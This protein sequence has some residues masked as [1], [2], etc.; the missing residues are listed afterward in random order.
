MKRLDV[1][2]DGI[3]RN[4]IRRITGVSMRTK[5]LGM[6]AGVVLLLG[7]AVTLQVR[8]RLEADLGASLEER[9]IAIA[10][11]LA[12]RSADLILTE[13]TFALHQLLRDTIENN[14][15]VRYVFMLDTNGN[16]L[17]QSFGQSVPR[18]LLSLNPV[19]SQSAYRVQVLDSE[20]G[21][22]D[23]VAMP[24]LSGRVGV[25]RVGLSQRRLADSV[26]AATWGLIGVTVIALVLGLAVA[27]L[28]THILT[29]PVTE[30][31]N[32]ARS[33][34]QGD[35]SVKARRHTDDEIGELASAFNTMTG[36]LVRSRAELLRRMSELGAL[37]TTAVAISGG[38]SLNHTLQAALDKVLEVMSLRAGWI[39]LVADD[40][41]PA[42][43]LAVQSGL[44]R[45]FASE[46]SERELG[47][48]VCARVLRNGQPLMVNDI[49]RE[50]PRLSADVI[51]AEGLICHA[52]VPLIAHERVVGVMNAA[53]A[54]AREFSAE[55]IALL[56]SVGRQIGVA[57]ENARL[58]EEVKRKEMLRGQLLSQVITAQEAERKRIARE[59]HDD[60]GQLLTTL[61]VGL[62][63]LEQTAAL[64]D[65]V[66]RSVAD[67]RELA[68]NIFD[69]VHRLAV[70][71]RPTALD[72]LGLVKALESCLR[73]FGG[74][75]GLKT[76]FEVS[77]LNG[78][79]LPGDVEITIYRVTQEALS[80][81]AKHAAASHVGMMLEK[82]NGSVIAV[83]EDDGRG[84]EVE[85]AVSSIDG[86]RP[87]LGLFGMQERVELIGGR[88]TI[89]S[90]RD[91]GTTVFV[92]IPLNDE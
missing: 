7:L 3:L 10:R 91:A 67:L 35:L 60:A 79:R 56:D 24:I 29:R 65:S 64:P 18:D 30:L 83:I 43:H 53:S 9:G 17:V 40:S 81:V 84:F 12:A 36:D 6:V 39:F 63:T 77:G 21:L 71:L 44:S 46:E 69:E 54:Q 32:V 31:V 2:Q 19:D 92:E 89:E 78:L 26:T 41:E 28:L 23:D 75:V 68:K 15:D 48:C 62:R 47:D 33:V 13:N 42:L 72:Q 11:D 8:A 4:V 87:H 22:I 82:R 59:L 25:A 66:Q 70:E 80:N 5:I 57:V 45:A 37:N 16:V 38:Q 58:W 51:A 34:G 73:D 90:T 1:A 55:E 49:R 88:L 85:S 86:Q 74:R 52:S 50:C 20:E 14:P 27:L 76:D 61:L